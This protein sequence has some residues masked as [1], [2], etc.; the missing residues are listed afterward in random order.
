MRFALLMTYRELRA[1]WRRLVFF[2]VCLSLGVG[3]I[4]AIRSIIQN[5][6]DYTSRES[7]AINSGDILL[8]ASA[9]PDEARAAVDRVAAPPA[10][11]ARTETVEVPTMLRPLGGSDT[12]KMV[13]LKGVE[14]GYPLY[15]R[16]TL[17]GGEPFSHELLAGSGAVVSPS[18]AA[19]LG[20]EVGSR[21]RIGEREF[22]VRGLLG[23]EPDSGLGAF[24]L[25]SR[26]FVSLDDLR[27]AGLLGFTARTR[28]S[29]HLR[30]DDAQYASTLAALKSELKGEF[31]SV[32]GY[33][34]AE[35]GLNNQ[36][37]LAADYLSLV[38]LAILALGGVGIWSVT[39]VYI[40]QRW[41]SI[42]VLKCLGC[43]NAMVVAAYT[44]QMVA[45][46]LLGSAAGVALAELV[47]TALRWYVAQGPLAAVAVTLTPGAIAQGFGVGVLVALLFSLTPLL[48]IRDIRPNAVLRSADPG[49]ARR[50]NAVRLASAAVVLAGLGAVASWQAGSLRIGMVFLGGLLAAGLA[51]AGVGEAL[52][53]VVG[54]TRRIPVFALRHAVLGLNRPGNQTRAILVALGLGVFFLVG[55]YGVQA[56]LL[57]EL[58]AQVNSELPD[59]YLIDV[60][61]D[62]VLD[63]ARI[64][65]QATGRPPALVPTLRA[66][67][68]ALEGVPL[69]LERVD[70]QRDRQRL[71]REYTLT[72]RA[73]L[74]SNEEVIAGEWWD[75]APSERPE[76]SIEESLSRDFGLGVGETMTFDI[77]G[78]SV[79]ATIANVRRV[80]WRNSRLGFMIVVRPNG[81]GDLP[82]VYIGALK[83]PEDAADRGRLGRVLT[84]S[85]S[86]V[87]VIDARDVIASVARVLTAVTT[88]ISVI[89]LVV[90]LAGLLILVGAI[91]M[92]R[93]VREYETAVMKTL[94]AK[95][96]TLLGVLVT[97][98]SLLGALAGVV[99]SALGVVLAWVVSRFVFDLTWDFEPS[100]A[101]AGIAGATVLTALVGIAS[102]ADLLVV[103]P[104]PVLRRED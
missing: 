22:A 3:A 100:I 69:D 65:T 13:E 29:V 85:H 7:R 54:R 36:L 38:G 57:R 6:N 43:T 40:G 71:G 39:R 86:N 30:V 1:S 104:L 87:S 27:G 92:T 96:P 95:S 91:A 97:E 70:N 73:H 4:V 93:Y 82:L 35:A 98:H 68:S 41:R 46:G 19:E 58:D 14:A 33:S 60:Q 80:D 84:D 72:T 67:I 21:F 45:I 16:L 78:E 90:L 26:V 5:V 59:L 76:I 62:Q 25:G 28:Q 18:L 56:T 34:E 15:G 77:Q 12:A 37:G 20:L 23:T 42:A 103:K 88:A 48:G 10:V 55:T 47:A 24:S 61:Q 8:R 50:W 81:L 94:G 11:T 44:L 99:G 17:Q 51:S 31:V 102:S 63:V 9:W 52:V 101:A 74:E 2:T 89:G 79:T 66:R 32:R 49:R 83:G 53:R 64:V 75:A